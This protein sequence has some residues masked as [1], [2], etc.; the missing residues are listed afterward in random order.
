M[1]ALW[2][3]NHVRRRTYALSALLCPRAAVLQ[4]MEDIFGCLVGANGYLTPSGTQGLAPHYDDVDVFI[5]QTEV[6]CRRR[7]RTRGATPTKLT[8]RAGKEA[9][10][11]LCAAARRGITRQL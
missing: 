5:M 10:E 4:L 9:L 2:K 3:L 1:D 7:A 11:G 8:A 6:S